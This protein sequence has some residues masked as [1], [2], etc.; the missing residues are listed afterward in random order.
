MLEKLAA[1]LITGGAR[2]LTRGRARWIGCPPSDS[3][4]IY[5]ANHTSHL[6]FALLWSALQPQQRAKTRPVAAEDY[7]SANAPRRYLTRRVFHSVLVERTWSDRLASP[8]APML[9]ALDR[10]D[11]LVLFPEGTRGNGKELLPFKAGI[12]HVA[13]ERPGVE[14][15]PVWMDRSHRRVTFGA[16]AHIEPNEDKMAFLERVRHELLDLKTK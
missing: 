8:I 15:V 2:L 4:R 13:R 10:G 6:D 16:P 1:A 9:E 5:F 14:L 7:W 3:Q 11:S 12:F